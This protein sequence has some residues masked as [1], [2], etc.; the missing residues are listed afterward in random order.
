M[1]TLIVKKNGVEMF[2]TELETF[3]L[4]GNEL[5][6]SIKLKQFIDMPMLQNQMYF[7]TIQNDAG[8]GIVEKPAIYRSYLF[9]VTDTK[10][11][12]QDEK[13]ELIEV[14]MNIVSANQILFEYL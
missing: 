3:M 13:G 9:S 4:S 6:S 12:Q 2:S 7:I 10:I 8:N 11:Q 1:T 5:T 14:P